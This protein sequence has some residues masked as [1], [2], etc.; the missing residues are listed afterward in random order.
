[1]TRILV[2]SDIHANLTAL[3]AVLADAGEV[4]ETWCL[5]D[6]VGYGPDPN[7]CIHRIR[8]L[9]KLTC[10]M[11]NHDTAAIGNLALVSFN[12]D[13]RRSLVWHKETVTKKNLTF[14]TGLPSD[15]VVC[16]EVSLAHG[17]PRDPIWE[18]VMNALTARINLGFF[19]TPWCFI[20]HS[21]MQ[22][23]FQQ[24]ARRDSVD[25]VVLPPGE[26]YELTERA[27]LNP[28]SVGQPRDRNPRAAYALF[29]PEKNIWE[30]RRVEYDIQAV[31]T[32]I[33]EAG[34]PPRHA[35]R[36]AGGW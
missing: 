26:G 15:V 7:E 18:Y 25:I 1:V 32:R 27:I 22:M 6:L 29:Y 2:I 23:V 11:G 19:S 21:H 13:A 8:S 14:L 3:E 30:P 16:G 36:L 28:G 35:E 9:P 31:K 12:H 10:L 4:D 20:G 33:L 34:L 17:S 5:G 24:C